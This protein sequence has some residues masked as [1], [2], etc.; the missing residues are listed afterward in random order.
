MP[1]AGVG[2]GS[3]GNRVTFQEV[4]EQDGVPVRGVS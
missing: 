4:L 2:P 3:G 1:G